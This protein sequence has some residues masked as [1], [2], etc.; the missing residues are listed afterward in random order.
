MDN[1]YLSYSLDFQKILKNKQ[2]TRQVLNNSLFL[3]ETFQ[4]WK[5]ERFFTTA[6]I[7]SNGKILDIGCANG[8]FLRCLQEWSD[9]DLLPYGID[10]NPEFIEAAKKLF[11]S[12][13]ENFKVSSL[14]KLVKL[15]KQ[16]FPCKY[17]FIYWAVWDNWW[18]KKQADLNAL[19]ALL[20]AVA[21]GGRLILGFY[22]PEGKWKEKIKILNDKGF[23]FSGIIENYANSREGDAI[24]WIDK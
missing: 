4:D 16:G 9:Y 3:G 2:I 15:F 7:N 21:C 11:R 23:K 5:N 6:A 24:A 22:R 19:S 8:F 14:Q 12:K 10:I 1:Q 13:E 17:N 18:F 20:E